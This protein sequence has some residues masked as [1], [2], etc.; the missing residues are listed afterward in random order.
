MSSPC[1][2]ILIPV[3]NRKKFIAECIQSALGQTFTDIEVVLVDNASDDGTWEICQQ[4]AVVDPRVR[5]FR[6]AENIGPVRN[7]MRC[8]LLA[9]GK[10]SKI[11]FSDDLL[12]L[13]CIARMIEPMQNPEIGFVFCAARIGQFREQS[14]IAYSSNTD[15]LIDSSKYIS[16]MVGGQAPVSP[17]AVLL[18]TADL[19]KNLHTDLPTTTKCSFDSNGA[20]PDVMIMLLTAEKY[21]KVKWITS[22]LVFFRVHAGS[23]TIANIDD[24]IT[25]GYTSA[26]SWYLINYKKRTDWLHYMSTVWQNS[27]RHQKLK[28]PSR[29]LKT[30]EGDGRLSDLIYFLS[31]VLVNEVSKILEKF[32]RF[33]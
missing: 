32:K 12:E 10:Y 13:D 7:W 25:Q 19:L 5:V 9:R 20:G 11:L 18:R 8:G 1:V 14:T 29:L 31:I 16:F 17:G 26:I 33:S 3:Y 30:N 15:Q 6:N 23:Y 2:S 24:K 21:P 28:N 22:P 27:P 4:F